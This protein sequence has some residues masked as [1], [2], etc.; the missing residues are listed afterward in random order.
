MIKNTP[1][2]FKTNIISLHNEEILINLTNT[3]F[4]N[5]ESLA[6]NFNKSNE[7]RVL[8]EMMEICTG[9]PK[10]SIVSEYVDE[11]S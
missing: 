10:S 1:S 8:V 5:K 2:N 7:V 11:F 9:I 6:K 4:S 3:H